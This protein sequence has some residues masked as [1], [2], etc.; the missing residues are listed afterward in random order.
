MPVDVATLYIDCRK[1]LLSYLTHLLRCSELAEDIAQ[2][3][4][5]ILVRSAREIAIEHPRGFLF[6]TAG[7]LAVD[8]IRHNKV[9]SK[10]AEQEALIGDD[11]QPYVYQQ[12]DTAKIEWSD[13]LHKT[14]QQLPARTRDILILHR[15]YR[16]S[17]K[18]IANNL[19]ISE[20]AVEKHI[21]RGVQ[22]C[23]KE[24]NDFF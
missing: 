24:L 22:L 15:L 21:S 1:E 4:F 16:F 18:E 20:S 5:A 23:R 8:H 2:E 6:R 14:L 13:L 7:N 9:I 12:D 19:N 3:S 10:H 11:I 17:Y